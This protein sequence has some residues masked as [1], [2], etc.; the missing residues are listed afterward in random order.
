MDNW[1]GE[2]RTLQD[3]ADSEDFNRRLLE[4][5]ND[6]YGTVKRALLVAER[7][8]GDI[9][10]PG[11]SELRDALEHLRRAYDKPDWDEAQI[12]LEEG[13]EHLRRAGVESIQEVATQR[14][15]DLRNEVESP[16]LAYKIALMDLRNRR[17][18]AGHL[19]DMQ[20]KLEEARTKKSD[21]ELWKD[22]V[23]DYLDVLDSARELEREIPPKSEAYYRI[24]AGV[25]AT[26]IVAAGVILQII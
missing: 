22:S 7:E 19:R 26:V 25:L 4:I 24:I 1:G 3:L 2:T 5:F 12:E 20:A 13:F 9:S 8:S 17:G 18:I 6:E 15:L 16:S 14:Y 21:K 10:Y 11:I 23:D